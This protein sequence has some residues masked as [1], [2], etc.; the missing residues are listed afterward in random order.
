MTHQGRCVSSIEYAQRI[1]VLLCETDCSTADIAL[2]IAQNLLEHRSRIDAVKDWGQG[3]KHSNSS[4]L[5]P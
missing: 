5:L 4:Q 1:H 2:K 3:E